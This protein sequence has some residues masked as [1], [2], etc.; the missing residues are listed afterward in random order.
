M[1]KIGIIGTSFISQ[2]AH[3]PNLRAN[4]DCEIVAVSDLRPKLANKV[5]NYLGCNSYSS[6]VEM[7]ENE[8]IDACYVVTHRRHTETVAHEVID[9]GVHLFTEKPMAQT[10]RGCQKLYEKA[11]S[12]NLIYSIGFMRR[13]DP[14]VVELKNLLKSENLKGKLGRLLHARFFLNAGGDYCNI[15]G[16]I[17][18]DEIRDTSIKTPIS[19]DFIDENYRLEFEHFVNVCG[20]NINLIRY[21][22]EDISIDHVSYSKDYTST[23][24]LRTGSIPITFQWGN[25]LQPKRW[26]E[27]IEII[28]EKGNIDLELQPAFLRNAPSKLSY[29]V[30]NENGCGDLHEPIMPW[31][32]AF[33][34]E[35]D[36]FVAA[37]MSNKPNSSSYEHCIEDMNLIENIWRQII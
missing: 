31:K 5:G 26:K 13:H 17:K 22:F 37:V 36:S 2:V 34:E 28:F 30:D 33:Q 4:K 6:G 10:Y 1:I 29:Y 8:E 23:I 15:Y 18:S 9:K 14:A 27:G 24:L 35:D 21:L 7:L 20:H 32:W 3:I 11:K 16:D 12:K 25:T 19:P